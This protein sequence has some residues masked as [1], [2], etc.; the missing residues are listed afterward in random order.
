MCGEQNWKQ[1]AA[2]FVPSRNPTQ[3]RQ[4]WQKVIK[5]G[6][7]KGAW[8]KEEDVLLTEVVLVALVAVSQDINRIKWKE[9]AEQCPGR[10][11]KKCRER[12]KGH[13]DPSINHGD[14]STQE[15]ALL[16]LQHGRLG[17]K[18][19]DIARMLVGRT[20]DK[21][22][23]RLRTLANRAKKG[24]LDPLARCAQ[25]AH[26]TGALHMHYPTH[27]T[28]QAAHT[29]NALQTQTSAPYTTNATNANTAHAESRAGQ[30]NAALHGYDHHGY[31]HGHQHG[32][33]DD[34][35]HDN[36]HDNQDDTGTVGALDLDTAHAL[37]CLTEHM[38]VSD[39]PIKLSDDHDMSSLAG[40]IRD[41]DSAAQPL[42]IPLEMPDS[43]MTMTNGLRPM[44]VTPASPSSPMAVSR[45]SGFLS[46]G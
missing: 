22:K 19:A 5:P 44:V 39:S 25:Q 9:I 21:V 1:V 15:D 41:W 45:G 14:F 26:A 23:S 10:T 36:Q 16:L 38:M 46:V 29:I 3:C 33:A 37:D 12:W 8:A 7:K 2:D 34:N 6:I 43:P 35:Q 42:E 28:T 31:H 32:Q 20:A 17:N 18:Y 27:A 11:Y 24:T 13:L 40:R 4:R 30:P